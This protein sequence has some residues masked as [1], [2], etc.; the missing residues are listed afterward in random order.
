LASNV[1]RFDV[2]GKGDASDVEKLAGAIDDLSDR[3][4][5]LDRQRAE[6]TVDVNTREAERN[7]GKFA[8]DLQRTITRAVE[9]LPD[10]ELDTDSSEADREIARIRTELKAI[11][12]QR[13]G[14]DIDA[15]SALAEVARLEGELR[16]LGD[17]DLSVQ[18]KADVGAALG[19][20]A[21][22]NGEINRL[23][24]RKVEIKFD[25]DRSLSESI[26]QIAAL[27]RALGTLVMPAAAVA[28][29][30]QIAAIGAAAITATGALGLIPA[31]VSS[32]ALAVNTLKVGFQGFA[33]ALDED[34]A[35]A[36][37]ALKQLAPAAREAATAVRALRP[38]WDALQ[39]NVQDELFRGLGRSVGQLATAYMPQ[40]R[41][42][43]ADVARSFNDGA[44]SVTEFLTNGKNVDT[45]RAAMR[46]LG[47]TIDNIVEAAAPLTS[48]FVDVLAE[49]SIVLRELTAGTGAAAS[50]FADM[51]REARA[52]GDLAAWIRDGVEEVQQLGRIAG[53]IGS[54]LYNV[55][56]TAEDA[57]ASFLDTLEDITSAMSEWTASAQGQDT[58]AAVFRSIR[59]ASAAA[60]PG[61]R[62][63][64]DAIASVVQRIGDAGVLKAAGEAFSAL[65]REAAPLVTQ[66]G[67]LAPVVTTVLGAIRDLAPVLIPAAAALAGLWAAAKLMTGINAITSG[68]GNFAGRIRDL[69]TAMSGGGITGALKGLA[70]S[71]GTGGILGLA[72]AGA[73]VALSIYASK[74]ADAAQAAADHKAKV[75]ALAGSLNTYSGA[76]TDATRAQVAQELGA[77]KLADGTTSYA[78]AL[79]S[80]GVSTK[81]FVAATTGNEQALA[82]VR[83]QLDQSVASLIRSSPVYGSWRRE[84]DAAG[85]SLEDLAA[86]AQGNAPAMDRVNDAINRGSAGA[87]E[88]RSQLQTVT[89][90]LMRAGGGSAE[91]GAELNKMA[92]QFG[93]AQ[94]QVRD[95]AQA[96]ADFGS[97]LDAIKAGFAGLADG[98]PQTELMRAGLTDLATAARDAAKASAESATQLGGVAAGGKAAAD[99]MQQSRDAFIQ[100][101]TA[102]GL[103]QEQAASLADQLGLI[104]AVTRTNFET[105]ATEVGSQINTI[106]AQFDAVPG[107]KSVTVQA[108]TQEAQSQLVQL[109]LNV[110]QLPDGTFRVNADTTAAKAN[111]DQFV[112]G[113]ANTSGTV[114]IGADSMPAQQA[115]S[116]ILTQIQSGASTVTINGQSVPAEAA[117]SYVLGLINQSNGTTTINGQ[118]VPARSAL[119]AYIAAVNAGS[120]TVSING[121]DV[122]A[123]SVL[124]ALIGSVN[125]SKGTVQVGANTSAAQGAVNSFITMNNGRKIN[126]IVTT[127]GSGGVASAGR[128][129]KGGVI[130]PMADG[131][132]LGFANGGLA[133]NSKS[134]TPMSSKRAQMVPK[135]TWRVI[136]DN[137]QHT[138]LYAPLD[139]SKRSLNYI[140]QGAAAYGQ[141]LVPRKSIGM[142]AGGMIRTEDGSY[143]NPSFYAKPALPAKA[144]G[145]GSLGSLAVTVRRMASGGLIRAEDGSY[146][147]ASFYSGAP[148]RATTTTSSGVYRSSPGST[149]AA[150]A[151][152]MN[153]AVFLRAIGPVLTLLRQFVDQSSERTTITNNFAI[154]DA[155]RAA[156][157][158]A[159][160][161]RTQAALGLFGG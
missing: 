113:A 72:L 18:M 69:G 12:D 59:D 40:L 105:N 70:T 57:G 6:P 157:D 116:A 151:P 101:A 41:A 79:G 32:A 10:I 118:D 159:R 61:V 86:A 102:A 24:G 121:Q 5:T 81:D 37:E 11:T 26:V 147:P 21:A 112:A 138:E 117:L 20:L 106:K 103:T 139:G 146:V 17:V 97:T 55:F 64:V 68:V 75:D 120:G 111:L 128:L 80:A 1:L 95:A 130:K 23:D 28:A 2:I 83:G 126:I 124:S 66:L 91:L 65:A 8:T 119:S 143:V 140:R 33:D 85:I 152:G 131:G 36:A 132:V 54:T 155:R 76:A 77:R 14:I 27:G 38:A 133:V 15:D 49:G 122:P 62:A 51:V 34:P 104:P 160:V 148:A 98:A 100:S 35:K 25:A 53:N 123:K 4:R 67:N 145:G 110:T 16:A 60:A 58:I 129:A 13:I 161:Q 31:V 150:Q 42:T 78:A 50:G 109:G 48:V 45:V 84:L 93:Q 115:L 158:V 137:M 44:K 19:Q 88:L 63:L 153:M 30:P 22:V 125:S 135:N 9:S 71:L 74:Q 43:M 47:T 89:S 7:V 141:V 56:S 94:Q 90:E 46:N 154:A 149:R 52:S 99:S 3:L 92:G 156:D 39:L 142:A 108:L 134:L 107:T 127:T 87:P 114:K 144:A 96:N 73:G 82:K 29:A 136:G